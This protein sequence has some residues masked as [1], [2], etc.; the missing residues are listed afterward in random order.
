MKAVIAVMLVIGNP[1]FG[2][3]ITGFAFIAWRRKAIVMVKLCI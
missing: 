3:K 1:Y 2:E